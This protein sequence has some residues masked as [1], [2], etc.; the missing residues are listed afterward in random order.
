MVRPRQRKYGC[1]ESAVSASAPAA[2][3]MSKARSRG[4]PP[5]QPRPG[6]TATTARYGQSQ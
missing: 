1:H 5:D 6:T 4:M 3:T 2:G